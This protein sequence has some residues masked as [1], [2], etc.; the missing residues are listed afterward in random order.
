MLFEKLIRKLISL[1]Q[2]REVAAPGITSRARL[3]RLAIPEPG[4]FRLPNLRSGYKKPSGNSLWNVIIPRLSDL[5]FDGC[6]SQVGS[7]VAEKSRHSR[8]RCAGRYHCRTLQ[9]VHFMDTQDSH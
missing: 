4:G 2:I 9:V 6:S 1:D 7:Q 5:R 8:L 3:F